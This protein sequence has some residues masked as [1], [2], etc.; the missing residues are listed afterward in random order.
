MKKQLKIIIPI[1]LLLNI[2]NAQ[3][4]EFFNADGFFSIGTFS[5]RTASI[6]LFDIDQDGDLDALVANG[7]HWAEQN[8]VF[9]NNGKGL[10]SLALPIGNTLDASYAIK[11]ADFNNDGFMDIAVVNDNIPNKIYFGTKDKGFNNESTFGSIS[12]SRNLEIS[13]ID[14]DGDIDLIISNR[15]AKNEI[16]LND[17]KG[18]FYT[19]IE[20]GAKEDQ[21]IQTKI[22]DINKDGFLDIITA[23]RQAKNKIYINDGK[24]NFILT[25]EFGDENQETRAIDIADINKDGFLDIVTGS[26][27]SKN[28]IFFGDKSLSYKKSYDFSTGRM[29]STIKIEDLN[30]DGL[31]DIVEGNYEQRNYVYLGREDGTFFEIGLREDLKD[32]T[33]NITT[34]DIN[35]DGYPDII[36]SNSGSWNIYYRTVIK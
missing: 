7:R 10:F 36:E 30:N 4:V 23:E 6:T 25:T 14:N 5:N 24:N 19:I 8:Y 27:E 21:T 9:Y 18:N 15:K 13:D 28:S 20:Y 35:N 3:E 29:T 33:Y 12:T 34:G 22:V 16:C 17:G 2:G 32:D 1:W 31:L 11:S 26:I